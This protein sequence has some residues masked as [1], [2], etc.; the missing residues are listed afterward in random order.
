M[1]KKDRYPADIIA[2]LPKRGSRLAKLSWEAGQAASTLANALSHPWSKGERLI[3]IA[4]DVHPSAIWPN[5]YLN[6]NNKR[7]PRKSFYPMTTTEN[8]ET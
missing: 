8:T 4:L 5:R 3:V 7:D 6:A 2:A 1:T